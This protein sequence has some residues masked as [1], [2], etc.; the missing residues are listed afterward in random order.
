MKIIKF[1]IE[2]I[3]IS[4]L[5]VVM[6]F[7][8]YNFINIKIL[9]KDISDVNG[10]SVLEVVSGSMEPT[11]KKGD[12]IIINTKNKK[13]KKNDIV[14]F[15]DVNGAFVTHRIVEIKDDEMITKGDANDSNDDPTKLDKIVGK[16]VYKIPF[17]GMLFQSFK[18]PFM[19][20]I[21]MLIGILFCYLISTDKHGNLKDDINLENTTDL[22]FIRKW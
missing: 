18:N 10:Y 6:A 11:I 14:T 19:L 16:F 8:A 4:I 12:L 22:S 7:N 17:L 3:I 15:Y 21:I 1:I 2:F 20:T 13:Y 5:L 9:G